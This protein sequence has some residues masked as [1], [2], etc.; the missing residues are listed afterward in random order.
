MS[1]SH[2]SDGQFGRTFFSMIIGGVVLLFVLIA[3]ANYIGGKSGDRLSDVQQSI[4]T[5]ELAKQVQ[6]V[7]KMTVG[8]VAAAAP[9]TAA[10]ETPSGKSVYESVCAGCHAAGVAGAPKFGDAGAWKDRIAQGKDTLYKHAITGFQGKA[11]FMPPKGGANI[12]D[13]AVKAAVD[14]MAENVK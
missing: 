7:G 13:D 12:A 10:A 14:Y 8:E 1:D 4:R 5:K 3:L 2:M 6:P 9:A 11:G